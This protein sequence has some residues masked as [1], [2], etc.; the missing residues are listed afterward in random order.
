MQNWLNI[1][2]G[3]TSL[4]PIV[5]IMTSTM[6]TLFIIIIIIIIAI[7]IIIYK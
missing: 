5:L 2:I 4:G 3:R 1:E 6:R 7:I